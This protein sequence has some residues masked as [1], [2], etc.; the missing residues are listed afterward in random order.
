G[1]REAVTPPL[2]VPTVAVLAA[3]AL[4][5][6]TPSPPAAPGQTTAPAGASDRIYRLLE[7]RFDSTDQARSSP[8]YVAFQL[9]ACPADA[10]PLGPRALY[11]EWTRTGSDQAPERQRVYVLDPGEPL[12]ST[13]NLRV[14]ELAVPGSSV[15]ACASAVPPRFTREELVERVGCAMPMRAE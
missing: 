12:E 14:F 13:A 6:A 10:P 8:G 7:G 3:L 1:L 9:V 11:V 15:G 5:C 4:G 2:P